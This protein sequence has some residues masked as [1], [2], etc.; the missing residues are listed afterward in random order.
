MTLLQ[1]VIQALPIYCSMVQA[2]PLYFLKEFD[3]L[4]HQFLWSGNLQNTKC[5]L[6]NWDLFVVQKRKEALAFVLLSCAVKLFLPS[7]I[8]VGVLVSLNF[9]PVSYHISIYLVLN[10]QIFPGFLLREEAL[11]CGI[12]SRLVLTY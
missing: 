6:I 4:S 1:S 10:L 11:W 8:G 9:G 12:P 2:A 7:S 3:A 5:S